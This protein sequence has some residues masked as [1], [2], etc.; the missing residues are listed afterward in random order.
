[1]AT[2]PT[3]G[4]VQNAGYQNVADFNRFSNTTANPLAGSSAVPLN[5]TVLTPSGVPSST[6]VITSTGASDDYAAKLA[7]FNQVQ[8]ANQSQQQQIQQQQIQAQQAKAQQDTATQNQKNIDTQ[9]QQKQAEIDAKNKALGVNPPITANVP[10]PPTGNPVTNASATS[11]SQFNPNTG[12]PIST[13]V[14]QPNTSNLVTDALT[15]S[16]NIVNSGLQDLQNAK[17]SITAQVNDQ[18]SSILRGTFPLSAPQQAL[19]SSMQNQLAQNQSQQKVANAAYTGAVAQAGFRSGGEYTPSQYAG[20]IANAISYGT[21]KMQDLDNAASV[22]MAQLQNDFQ[23]QDFDMINKNYDILNKQLDDKANHLKDMYTTVTSN[24]K[25]QR[26]QQQK[27]DASAYQHSQDKIKNDQAAQKLASD[28]ATNTAQQAK[29]YADIRNIKENLPSASNNVI[30]AN[31]QNVN[32]YNAATNASIGLPQNQRAEIAKNLNQL[33]AS[34]D[35]KGAK[36]LLIRTAFQGQ[37]GSE[38]TASIQRMQA[39][40]SLNTVKSLL[41]GVDTNLAKGTIQNVQQRLGNSGDPKL[42]AINNRITQALQV[43]RN[44][45]TGAAWGTQETGEYKQLFPALTNT[46]KLNNTIIDSMTD[47]LNANQ[48]INL[49]AYIGQGTYDSIFNS[50]SSSPTLSQTSEKLSQAISAGYSPDE[51][52]SELKN[53]PSYGDQVRKAI[54]AGYSTQEVLDYLKK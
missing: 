30:G 26:E 7:T 53:D 31:P 17:D 18:L 42:V 35:T 41:S 5:P 29:L 20:Q 27:S 3:T 43:Y 15:G 9:N 11:Q 34:G 10:V 6:P 36:E 49:G 21:A 14:S 48:R 12:Q 33:L 4:T 50:N 23:K 32:Y 46:N 44:A 39:I 52:V 28:I 25:D 40:D 8:Q 1:M 47:A 2:P 54:S 38:Q 22:T 37:T 13:A 45:I 19:V 16:T 51:I 24:L